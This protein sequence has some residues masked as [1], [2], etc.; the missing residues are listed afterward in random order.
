[1][2]RFSSSCNGVKNEIEICPLFL[3]LLHL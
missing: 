3:R 2:T 1:L